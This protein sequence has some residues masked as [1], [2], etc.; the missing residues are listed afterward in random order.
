MQILSDVFNMCLLDGVSL[1][2]CMYMGLDVR[3]PVFGFFDQA[4]LFPTTLGKGP[5]PKLGKK[6]ST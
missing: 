4:G 3:K 1:H 6:E 5:W 2:V